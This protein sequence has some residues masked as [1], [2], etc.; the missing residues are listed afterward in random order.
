MQQKQGY[1]QERA[2]LLFNFEIAILRSG[3]ATRRLDPLNAFLVLFL[4]IQSIPI[5]EVHFQH[6]DKKGR[7]HYFRDFP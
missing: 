2:F 1:S 5:L 6:G 7:G 3:Q 4:A